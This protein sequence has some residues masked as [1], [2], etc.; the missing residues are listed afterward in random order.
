MRRRAKGERLDKGDPERKARLGVIGQAAA[1]SRIDQRVEIGKAAQRLG[2]DGMGKRAIVAALD[3]LGGAVE[4]GL[5][6]QALTEHCIEQFQRG[7]ARRNAGRVV[8]ARAG[9]IGGTVRWAGQST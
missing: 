4:R 3:P 9:T 7:A 2:R 1:R 8:R 5:E 6:W